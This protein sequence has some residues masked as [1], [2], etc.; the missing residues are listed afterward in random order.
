MLKGQANH[1]L[2]DTNG[3]RQIR[4][5]ARLFLNANGVP[6]L[7]TR[8]RLYVDERMVKGAVALFGRG[9]DQP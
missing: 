5:L 2:L 9:E 7:V 8:K 1:N 6:L 3:I 4:Q